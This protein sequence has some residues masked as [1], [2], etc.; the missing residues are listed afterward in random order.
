M[1]ELED[2]PFH[3][4]QIRGTCVPKGGSIRIAT[5]Q[6]VEG[7]TGLY[8]LMVGKTAAKGRLAA[9]LAANP[10]V[11]DWKISANGPTISPMNN[12][13]SLGKNVASWVAEGNWHLTNPSII[14]LTDVLREAKAADLKTENTTQD[15][16]RFGDFLRGQPLRALHFDVLGGGEVPLEMGLSQSGFYSTRE[17]VQYPGITVFGKV[18][19]VN[20][21][22]SLIFFEAEKYATS[23]GWIEGLTHPIEIYCRSVRTDGGVENKWFVTQPGLHN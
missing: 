6:E 7:L 23:S 18:R 19:D 21:Q 11:Q 4:Q 9:I 13:A 22:H 10:N 3:D 2:F 8:E 1:T 17:G 20:V 15:G 16:K 14:S 5:R 12:A